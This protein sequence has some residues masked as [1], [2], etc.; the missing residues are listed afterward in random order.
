MEMFAQI[1]MKI[2]YLYISTICYLELKIGNAK[3]ITSIQFEG[4]FLYSS[5]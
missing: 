2:F 1:E 5:A 4:P 3:L